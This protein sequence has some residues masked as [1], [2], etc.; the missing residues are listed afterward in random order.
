M[1]R[2]VIVG[3]SLAGVHAASA[4]R[5]DGFDGELV[6]LD[7]QDHSPY[8]RPPLSKELL[9]GRFGPDEVGL[10]SAQGLDADWR[11]GTWATGLDAVSGTVHTSSGTVDAEGIVIATG[12][13]PRL[14]PGTG[15]L[16]DVQVL[17]T[18]DDALALRTALDSGLD[19]VVV[20]G[21]GFIGLEVA[22]SCRARGVNVTL[23]EPLA[24]PLV[25]I[26]GDEVGAALADVHR[27][28]G[29]DVRLGT[30]VAGIERAPGG[31]CVRLDDGDAVRAGRAIVGIGVTP[32]TGWLE[33]SGALIDNG[34]VC[35]ATLAVLAADGTGPLGAPHGVTVVAAGDLARWPSQRFGTSLR[36]EHWDHAIASG[37]A[38]ARRL[39]GGPNTPAF[40]PVPWFWS[41]QYDTKI[42]LVGLAGADADREVVGDLAEGRFAVA[43]GRNGRLTGVLG[44]N[45][46]RHVALMRAR[47]TEGVAFDDGVTALRELG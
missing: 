47:V 4:L 27:A 23:V 24:Q 17:R 39:L 41:D 5:R 13:S 18:L 12:A 10:R 3:A 32:A 22:A 37:E 14:L 11:T 30:G 45:R 42:Q 7:G 19:S 21:A 20:V 25:R 46:P 33:D 6:V 9:T 2:V 26:L 1:R 43:Y 8:D 35:D 34:V 38:A 16:D 40:D 31:V 28:Q 44:V 29:V 36:V 15:D